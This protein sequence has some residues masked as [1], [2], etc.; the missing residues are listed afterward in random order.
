MPMSVVEFRLEG[1]AA[2]ATFSRPRVM[3]ASNPEMKSRLLEVFQEAAD[4]PDVCFVVLTG[5]GRAVCSG[6]DFKEST[7]FLVCNNTGFKSSVKLRFA[8]RFE[9]SRSRSMRP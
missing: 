9:A 3:S 6:G 1:A 5:V 8:W 7:S 4:A 2:L